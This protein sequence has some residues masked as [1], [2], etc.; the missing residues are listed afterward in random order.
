MGLAPRDMGSDMVSHHQSKHDGHVH[1][2]KNYTTLTS[3]S[4]LCL[5]HVCFLLGLLFDPEDGE[6][7]FLRHIGLL[8]R[9]L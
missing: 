2:Q 3:S 9:T 1:E 7:V 4:T 6:N 8:Q 5:L